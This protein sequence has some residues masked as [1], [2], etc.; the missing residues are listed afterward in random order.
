M[1]FMKMT[2]S[3]KKIFLGAV[4]LIAVGL[5]AFLNDEL[6]QRY[7]AY[8]RNTGEIILTVD[9]RPVP[10]NNIPIH[11]SHDGGAD[12][13]GL[14]DN[15]TFRFRTGD[16]G[17]HRYLFVLPSSLWNNRGPASEVSFD[18]SFMSGNWWHVNKVKI[19]IEIITSPS[20]WMAVSGELLTPPD[21]FGYDS[22]AES[23]IFNRPAGEITIE[24]C[25]IDGI[26][27]NI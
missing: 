6:R 19:R 1:L 27:S 13:E 20:V 15:G 18:L 25:R 3:R 24:N 7:L 8:W 26:S 21:S 9:G 12:E 17:Q 11:F 4:V 22:Y 14:I 16:Y 10:L 2:H 23:F 5:C